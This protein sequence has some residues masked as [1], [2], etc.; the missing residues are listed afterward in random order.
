MSSQFKKLAVD[1]VILPPED[2][3][4]KLISINQEAGAKNEAW[5]SLG[6]DDFLPHI[7][8]A[9][10]GIEQ[11]NLET[12]KS[13]VEEIAKKFNPILIEL[14]ELYYSE[15]ADGARM[16][17]M[18]AKNSAELQQLHEG[19][20]NALKQYF[21]YDC[22]KGTLCSKADE[23]VTEPDYINNFATLYSFENFDP[24][25]TTRTKTAYGQE[26]LP[27]K[28]VATKLAAC[29]VGIMTTCRKELFA[30]D[31]D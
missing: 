9:M 6:K 26:V 23:K 8:M 27:L 21:S 7:S 31:L 19:L 30:V 1:I 2:V 20:M 25:I 14:N 15:M 24:H 17:C 22:T 29:H 12:V 4:D 13:I 10:G 5:G 28:F 3:I 18:R 11:N 16:Y